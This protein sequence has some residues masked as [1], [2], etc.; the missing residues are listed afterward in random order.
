[1]VDTPRPGPLAQF[2]DPIGVVTTKRWNRRK[3]RHTRAKPRGQ[4]RGRLQSVG[5]I[6]RKTLASGRG[7]IF[8]L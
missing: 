1:M 3:G 6:S 2:Q 5:W 8:F 7:R 4:N